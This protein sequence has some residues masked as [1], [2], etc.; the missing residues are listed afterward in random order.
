MKEEIMQHVFRWDISF[1]SPLKFTLGDRDWRCEFS[2]YEFKRFGRNSF[3]LFLVLVLVFKMLFFLLTWPPNI[4]GEFECWSF[5]LLGI[6]TDTQQSQNINKYLMYK[7]PN[8][9]NI[10]VYVFSILIVPSQAY[11][12]S[13]LSPLLLAIWLL[14][15]P[16]LHHECHQ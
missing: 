5:F 9:F 1:S 10:F 11:S 6:I 16:S 13:Q 14:G 4:S 12:H 2:L 3:Q 8:V 7:L 15:I